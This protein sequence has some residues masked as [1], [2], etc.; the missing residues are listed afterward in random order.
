MRK[1]FI[2][3][4]ITIFCLFHSN[5]QDSIPDQNIEP[6]KFKKT[7]NNL[8]IRHLL[9]LDQAAIRL[10]CHPLFAQKTKDTLDF[11]YKTRLDSSII[12]ESYINDSTLVY[13]KD[14]YHWNINNELP[15]FTKYKLI[16]QL[17][18]KRANLSYEEEK[19]INYW[20]FY[21]DPKHQYIDKFLHFQSFIYEEKHTQLIYEITYDENQK[22]SIQIKEI[23]SIPYM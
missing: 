17:L 4:L 10:L 14:S 12:R 20:P 21:S 8:K 11:I 13:I 3:S 16:K 19:L 23:K 18:K 6:Y 2:I 9:L 15:Q 5:G 1:T 7:A 22:H